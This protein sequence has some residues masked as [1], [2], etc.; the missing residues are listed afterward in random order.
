MNSG[1]KKIKNKIK[2]K[3]KLKGSQEKFLNK[4]LEKSFI[5]EKHISIWI[6]KLKNLK[7]IL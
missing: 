3:L 6:Q 4:Q 5:K 2:K 7:M 1:M